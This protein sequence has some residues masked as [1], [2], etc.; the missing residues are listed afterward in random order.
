MLGILLFA[1][2]VMKTGPAKI[3][4]S[5]ANSDYVYVLFALVF[6]VPMLIL[7]VWKWDYILRKQNIQLNFFY[8]MKLQM[9]SLFY[10]A[11]TPGRLGSFIK[12]P[13]LCRK[14]KKSASECSSNVVI[15]RLF[16]F[17]AVALFAAIGA[18]LFLRKFI[19][20]FYFSLLVFIGFIL[21]IILFTNK[22]TSKAILKIVFRFL[23]PARLKDKARISFE[24]FYESLP[25]LIK[26]IPAF[27]LTLAVWLI[28]YTQAYFVAFAFSLKVPYLYFVTT[29]AAVTLV[30]L[31]PITVSGLG[32]REAAL[33]TLLSVYNVAAENVVGFSILLSVLCLIIYGLFG[34][35]VMFKT[36]IE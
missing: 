35:L 5:F 8:L 33:L 15:D 36:K 25:S 34:M 26:L 9:I 19:G 17:T 1:Y 27:I 32:T 10:G 22:R 16:D 31:I 20:F 24:R 3:W 12:I 23:I 13:Y 29:F 4:V 14:T 30:S 2:I 6:F 28:I 18:V 21:A 11:V 7:Q